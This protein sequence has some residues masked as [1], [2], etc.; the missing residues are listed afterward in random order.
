MPAKRQ[1]GGRK[2]VEKVIIITAARKKAGARGSMPAALLKKRA[3]TLGQNGG[4]FSKED[5]KKRSNT[6]IELPYRNV[7]KPMPSFRTFE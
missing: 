5:L 2:E 4:A 7:T 3:K 6:R 1:R